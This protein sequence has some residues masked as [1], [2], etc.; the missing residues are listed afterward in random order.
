MKQFCVFCEG[1]LCD[2]VGVLIDVGNE[3]YLDNICEQ[4]ENVATTRMDTALWG[5]KI[6]IVPIWNILVITND[7][8]NLTVFHLL[9]CVYTKRSFENVP[10]RNNLEAC[11]Q[12]VKS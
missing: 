3:D 11:K 5:A 4:V 10:Y 1:Y 2:Q 6:E 12:R 9:Y 8:K 7:D